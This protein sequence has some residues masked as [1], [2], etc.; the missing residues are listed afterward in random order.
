MKKWIDLYKENVSLAEDL[1]EQLN[2]CKKSKYYDVFGSENEKNADIEELQKMI[3]KN[4]FD[5]IMIID[6]VISEL[7]IEK[8]ELEKIIRYG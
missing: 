8:N 6:E 2:T 3:E 1:K 4:K 7:R 5:K